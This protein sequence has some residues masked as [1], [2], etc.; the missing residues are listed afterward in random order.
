MAGR[1]EFDLDSSREVPLKSYVMPLIECEAG[2]S[3]R[4]SFLLDTGSNVSVIS[5][6]LASTWNLKTRP[7]TLVDTVETSESIPQYESALIDQLNASGARILESEFVVLKKL[8]ADVDGIIGVKTIRR[9]T[10]LIDASNRMAN[11]MREEN[12]SNYLQRKYPSAQWTKLPVHWR[13]A[14]VFF[15]ELNVAER[16]LKMFVDTGATATALFPQTVESLALPKVATTKTRAQTIDDDSLN[17]KDVFRLEG[18]ELGEWVVDFECDPTLNADMIAD[19]F[20]GILGFDVLRHVPTIFDL[21]H[22]LMW[23]MNP[24]TG[25]EHRIRISEQSQCIAWFEDPWP[26]TR[27]FFVETVALTGRTNC[28]ALVAAL[29][30]DPDAEV[31]GSAAAALSI[32]AREEWNAHSI[33]RDAMTWWDQ[34]RDEFPPDPREQTRKN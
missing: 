18:M 10:L 7:A 8:P 4:G 29:L 14:G 5:S 31:R 30:K 33:V 26:S 32:I 24:P 1:L 16:K 9:G 13:G 3:Q 27:K 28:V 22:D 21:G 19:G 6:D 20:D 11:L 15:L 25:L 2:G 12:L 23:V 34:H 17:V